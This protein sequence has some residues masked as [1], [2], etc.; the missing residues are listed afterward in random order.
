MKFVCWMVVFHKLQ[1]H[2]TAGCTDNVLGEKMELKGT[3]GPVNMFLSVGEVH[4]LYRSDSMTFV[5]SSQVMY[6]FMFN[7][8]MKEK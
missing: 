5:L 8:F 3:F 7:T 6:T 2:I 4:W 1:P